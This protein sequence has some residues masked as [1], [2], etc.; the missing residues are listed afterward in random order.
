M[1]FLNRTVASC[2]DISIL[3]HTMAFSAVIPKGLKSMENLGV[4]LLS[5]SDLLRL[6]KLAPMAN[7]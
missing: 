3:G 7:T 1:V 2:L 5:E 6:E 4:G